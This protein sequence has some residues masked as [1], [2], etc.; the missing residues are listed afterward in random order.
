MSPASRPLRVLIVDDDRV[1]G[2]I[3]TEVCRHAGGIVVEVA[4]DGAEALELA[5]SWRPDVL[6]LDMRLPDTDGVKL[7]PLL[8]QRCPGA[9]AYLCSADD[10]WAVMDAAQSA[11]FDGCWTK[12]VQTDLVVSDLR[13]HRPLD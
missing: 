5:Q 8:R 1:N 3:F 7:L 6:V 9:P 12:P 10:G 11:G 13:R 2:L 4:G